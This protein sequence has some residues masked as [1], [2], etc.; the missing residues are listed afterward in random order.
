MKKILTIVGL[1]CLSLFIVSC[2]KETEG[3]SHETN[4]AV[5]DLQ[6]GN[7]IFHTLGEP[8]VDPGYSAKENGQNVDVTVSISSLY[9]GYSGNTVDANTPDLYTIAYSATNS[10]G[11]E[12]STSREVYVFNTGD[13]VNSI[14]G[15]YTSTVVRNGSS[16]AQ[17][18]DMEYIFIT[19]TGD[20]TYSI[21][22][23]IGGYY[24]FGRAYGVDYSAPATVVA[25]SIPSNDFSFEQFSVGTFGGA[26]DITSLTVDPS[27][28]TIIFTSVWDS[29]YEFVV[30]LKQVQ[31]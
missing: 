15:L 5:F 4:Y 17:Y 10:D 6:G 31:I 26:V 30:T 7:T 24:Q 18:T 19:K 11:Y 8:F 27:S 20:N 14:E 3:I 13:M 29:G 1:A 21:S 28:K 23:G 9:N 22:C 12:A 25:N 2:E 16:G